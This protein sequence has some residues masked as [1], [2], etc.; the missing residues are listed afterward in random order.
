[1]H[2][3]A[4]AFSLSLLASLVAAV[5]VEEPVGVLAKQC[6]FTLGGRRFDMCP[7]FEGKDRGWTV[8]REQQTPPT[9]TKTEYRISF[10]G[11]L[12]RNRKIA[13]YEQ[14]PDGTW[15]CKTVTNTRPKHDGE[16][17]RVLQVISVAGELSISDDESGSGASEYVPGLNI[18]AKLVPADTETK[19][20]ILHL[21]LHGG[22]Y[23]RLQQK[24]DFQF[25]CDHNAEEPTSPT[26][27]WDW[28]GTHTFEWRTKHACGQ[29]MSAPPPNEPVSP[30]QPPPDD[31]APPKDVEDD[32]TPGEKKL[33]DPGFFGGRS[34]RS[35]V[36]MF[37]S[38]SLICAIVFLVYFPPRRL[39]RFLTSYVKA[40]PRVMRS[41]VGERVLVRWAREDFAIGPGEED[42]MI[43]AEAAALAEQIPL[44]PAPR[45]PV[46]SNYQYGS[47]I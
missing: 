8:S 41:H 46:V 18:T 16:E 30:T 3:I 44:K 39:R 22:Y 29:A 33:L 31:D 23:T 27:G 13:S 5:A 42:V 25:I 14:C 10:Q 37:A 21:H 35:V 43:N 6:D 47:A 19:H 32:D 24:A 11:P 40:H 20:D 34:R 12:K 26:I 28:R 38:A 36:T 17:P 4:I 9:I 7:V 45:R 2:G 1:M 15:I